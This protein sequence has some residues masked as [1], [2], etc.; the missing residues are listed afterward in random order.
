MNHLSM[1]AIKYNCFEFFFFLIKLKLTIKQIP[2]AQIEKLIRRHKSQYD[3]SS[4]ESPSFWT[5][6]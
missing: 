5:N 3:R 4:N 6:V 1:W 2:K